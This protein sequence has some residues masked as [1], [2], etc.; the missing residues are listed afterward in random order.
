MDPVA[1]TMT[2]TTVPN[3]TT[4]SDVEWDVDPQVSQGPDIKEHQRNGHPNAN[5]AASIEH[6][7][8]KWKR[9]EVEMMDSTRDIGFWLDDNAKQAR[10]RIES[11]SH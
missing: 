11:L 10:V 8:K 6:E 3:G 1:E 7:G 5:N 9:R 2:V 4:D